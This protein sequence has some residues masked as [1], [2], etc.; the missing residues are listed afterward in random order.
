MTVRIN[1]LYGLPLAALLLLVLSGLIPV[2]SVS[3]AERMGIGRKPA[4][5]DE[6]QLVPGVLLGKRLFED[7][8]LSEPPGLACASCHDPKA[9]FR[10]DN[11][12]RIPGIAAGSRP[13]V[14]GS[15]KVLSLLYSSYSPA[16][17]FVPR[18]NDVTGI[19]E[20][21]PVGGQFWDGRAG[22]LQE[23]VEGPLLNPREMNNTSKQAVVDKVRRSAYAD[24]VRDVYGADVFKDPDVF[25]KLASSIASYE[26]S[27]RFKPFSSKF[28]DWLEGKVLLTDQEWLGFQLFTDPKKGNCLS[29]HDGGGADEVGLGSPGQLDQL[30]RNPK[31]WLFT[32]FSYDALGVPRNLA[33][34]D[35]SITSH[36]D[37]GLCARPALKK[38]A[39][40]EF[41]LENLCGTFRVPTLRNVAINGPYMHNGFFRRLRDAVAFYFTRD[42]DPDLWYP[43]AA[44][45]TV[46][47]FNDLPVQ[48]RDNVNVRQ[49]PY[50]RRPG[51]KTRATDAE[52][53]AIVA[54][55]ETLTD[56]PFLE[57][58]PVPRH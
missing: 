24:L 23:Q 26:A 38:F 43:K 12:S 46:E 11:R 36:F 56:K 33:I 13:G 22:D 17:S 4:S 31:N 41:R 37:M 6:L 14:F 15:R 34:P 25:G 48:Y 40:A 8:A 35:N 30:S 32:D 52:I 16:F 1:R 45:G 49:V 50:D 51:E 5:A 28:D 58:S 3:A 57:S 7:T 29:C 27:P 44:N 19:V 55:L 47:K 9:A 42:T 18:K 21:V 10:G 2:M 54:F 20:I 53:D 39:P